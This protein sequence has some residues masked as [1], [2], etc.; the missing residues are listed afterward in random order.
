KITSVRFSVEFSLANMAPPLLYSP[1][2]VLLANRVIP[3]SFSGNSENS[4]P[5]CKNTAPPLALLVISEKT[6]HCPSATLQSCL[7]PDRLCLLASQLA[8]IS[9]P[10]HKSMAAAK[11]LAEKR[12][13]IIDGSRDKYSLRRK[14][15]RIFI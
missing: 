9:Y 13:A 2:T 15:I 7:M 3:V 5:C 4:A 6:S 10:W 12:D 1:V 11:P 8:L 14:I